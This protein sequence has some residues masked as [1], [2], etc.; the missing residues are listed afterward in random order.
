[1]VPYVPNGICMWLMPSLYVPNA[2]SMFLMVSYV[3]ND[4]LFA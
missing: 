1:M 4:T 2:L 3:P